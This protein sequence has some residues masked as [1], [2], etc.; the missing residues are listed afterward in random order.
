MDSHKEKI[1]AKAVEL[2]WQRGADHFTIGELAK[3]LRVSKQTIYKH[4]TSKHELVQQALSYLLGQQQAQVDL[5]GSLAENALQEVVWTGDYLSE[6]WQTISPSFMKDLQR[7]FPDSHRAFVH[8]T[9]IMVQRQL[10]RGMEEGYFRTDMPVPLFASLAYGQ[11]AYAFQAQRYPWTEVPLPAILAHYY[12]HFYLG[13]CTPE[14]HQTLW[15]LL[16]DRAGVG[17]DADFRASHG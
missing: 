15:A 10:S 12:Y 7:R 3:A 1:V 16:A 8:I 9:Q 2:V 6:R 11:Y 17:D 4:F 14:G 5:I 13:I